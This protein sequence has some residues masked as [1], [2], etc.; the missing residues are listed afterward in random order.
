MRIVQAEECTRAACEELATARQHAAQLENGLRAREREVER[1]NKL[2]G[3][4]KGSEHS[5][6]AQRVQVRVYMS[7]RKGGCRCVVHM[8]RGGCRCA[9]TR[10]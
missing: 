1:L 10:Q 4:S 3:Q 5:I 6:E 8:L 7:I 2:L 9:C